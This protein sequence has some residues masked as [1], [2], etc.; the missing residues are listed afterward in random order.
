[1]TFLLLYT[2]LTSNVLDISHTVIQINR[3]LNMNSPVER[4]LSTKTELLS[5]NANLHI[6]LKEIATELDTV[7]TRLIFSKHGKDSRANITKG[8]IRNVSARTEERYFELVKTY[9]NS[10]LILVRANHKKLLGI[11]N[12]KYFGIGGNNCLEI[13]KNAHARVDPL[14]RL[15]RTCAES[16]DSLLQNVGL[17]PN[18]LSV[19]MPGDKIHTSEEGYLLT[20]LHIFKNAVVSPDGDVYIR[21]VRVVPWR[22]NQEPALSWSH[23]QK[24]Q[25]YDEVS[26]KNLLVKQPVRFSQLG[27]TMIRAKYQ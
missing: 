27:I 15:N 14:A 13:K 17:H 23:L 26:V 2:Y 18:L 1:M 11:I 9:T 5:K 8:T 19:G 21:D 12:D 7:R 4:N 6:L 20:Y 24:R 16:M 10:E 22:C 3:I 25:V